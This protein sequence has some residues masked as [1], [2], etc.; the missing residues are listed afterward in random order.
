M[1]LMNKAQRTNK[2]EP[3]MHAKGEELWMKF[4]KTKG[5]QVSFLM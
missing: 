4:I 2:E 1:Q 3:Y 5:G